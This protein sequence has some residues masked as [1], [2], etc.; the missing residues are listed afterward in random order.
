MKNG[1]CPNCGSSE[2]YVSE[3]PFSESITVK[4]KTKSIEVFQTQAY[5]CLACQ[6]VEIYVM[7]N[8]A[9]FF[10]KGKELKDSVP[11]SENWKKVTR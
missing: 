9:S 1:Q 8:S 10:G 2:I 5:L 3:H 4:S 6:K 11:A 7:E